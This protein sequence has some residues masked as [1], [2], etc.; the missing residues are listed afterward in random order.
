MTDKTFTIDG[1]DG[2]PVEV[3]LRRDKRLRKSSRWERTPD[4]GILLRVPYRLPNKH[5]PGLLD[6]IAERLKRQ[7]RVAAKRTDADLQQRAQYINRTHFGGQ[8]EWNA[9]RWVAPMKTRL[10][11]CTSGGNTDGHIRIS[12]EIATWPQWV[13]DYVIAHEMAHRVHANHSTAFWEFLENAYPL[14]ERARGFIKGVGFAKGENWE[15]AE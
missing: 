6:T 14:T 11:S 2:N 12:K 3:V 10:G 4:G 15:E 13:V 8:I 1:P 9:I 5:I 7:Q